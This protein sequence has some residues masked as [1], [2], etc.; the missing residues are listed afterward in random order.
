M[1]ACLGQPL[2]S[3]ET[4]VGKEKNQ[5]EMYHRRCSMGQDMAPDLSSGMDWL[6]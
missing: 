5:E 1:S 6:R 2:E 4:S 3:P